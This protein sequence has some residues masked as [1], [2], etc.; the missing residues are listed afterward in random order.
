MRL[1]G[2]DENRAAI[3]DVQHK[4]ISLPKVPI[5]QNLALKCNPAE[6]LCGVGHL[7]GAKALQVA[8]NSGGVGDDKGVLP[9]RERIQQFVDAVCHP[10]ADLTEGLAVR[11]FEVRVFVL[12]FP[13]RSVLPG[14]VAGAALGKAGVL[15]DR[16]PQQLC[17]LERTQL[18]VRPDE[19]DRAESVVLKDCGGPLK[20]FGRKA[21]V[22]AGT[23]ALRDGMAQEKKGRHESLRLKK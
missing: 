21:R 3:F 12:A 14:R 9:L 1:D 2:A 22:G 11:I 15:P 4:S 7:N 23:A 19:R 10:G 6:L 8:A 5:Q 17:G 18:M 13:E 16:K 20:T